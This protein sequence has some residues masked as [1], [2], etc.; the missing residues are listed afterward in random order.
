MKLELVKG[1]GVHITKRE[2]DDAE[3]SSRNSPT[4]PIRNI[5]TIFFP[6]RSARYI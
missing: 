3:D 4:R 1:Y 6:E 5:I 2:V